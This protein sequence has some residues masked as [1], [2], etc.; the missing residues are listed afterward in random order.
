MGAISLKELLHQAPYNTDSRATDAP[1]TTDM[2]INAGLLIQRVNKLL[3][4]W[5]D[6]VKVSS[7]YRP[8]VYN[9][10]AHGA[11]NSAHLTCEAVDISDPDGK[12]G[13]F[14]M[15]N[16]WL[17]S[18]ANVYM[19]DPS[20]TPTWVHLQIRPTKSNNRVFKP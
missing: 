1:P 17:L 12:L 6:K 7:G 11:T 16:Q 13:K 10:A 20:R 2:L 9:K 18:L 15:E 3:R 14:I 8:P 19:E 5:S 4:H